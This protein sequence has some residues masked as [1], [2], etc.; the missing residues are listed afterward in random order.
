M[1]RTILAIT[2][3]AM[4]VSMFAFPTSAAELPAPYIDLA[5]KADGTIYDAAGNS[6]ISLL[7]ANG[8]AKV[9]PM[10]VTL[11]DGQIY[12]T[13]AVRQ[14]EDYDYIEIYVDQFSD[15]N[16]WIEFVNKG[17]T[18][19]FYGA[20][21]NFVEHTAGIM[22][23]CKSGNVM[24]QFRGRTNT[25]DSTGIA[26]RQIAWCIGCTSKDSVINAG[27][28][29]NGNYSF[30]GNNDLGGDNVTDTELLEEHLGKLV[31]LVGTYNVETKNLYLYYNGVLVQTGGM[32]EAEFKTGT[33]DT[34]IIAIGMNP[35][36]F[37]ESTVKTSP[38]TTVNARVYDVC[39]TDAQVYDAF[40]K[41]REDVIL[42]KN[43]PEGA[44]SDTP[45]TEAPATE[46]PATEAPVTEAPATEAPA[47]EPPATEAPVENEAGAG[48]AGS[49]VKLPG[50][51]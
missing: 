36:Q 3:I 13:W 50:E 24:L 39:L 46:A 4:L 16:A 38:M 32:G 25:Y 17:F 27:Y 22:G 8:N 5:Y 11:D 20:F 2:V 42:G 7:T 49:D 26:S 15:P 14:V 43:A 35:G 31:H 6:E 30:A 51:E 37:S 47:T 1:K 21:D 19:E 29:S 18:Y 10:E 9:G 23:N 44:G 45:A 48:E 12:N 28:F 40:N 41:C 34:S 33:A